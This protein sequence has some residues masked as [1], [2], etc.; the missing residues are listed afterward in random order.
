LN[1]HG[2][3]L[4]SEKLGIP[5][6]LMIIYAKKEKRLKFRIQ[7]PDGFATNWDS[8]KSNHALRDGYD[9]SKP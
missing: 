2:N 5:A 7:N 4:T 1:I 8:Q 9:L 6:L 3:A